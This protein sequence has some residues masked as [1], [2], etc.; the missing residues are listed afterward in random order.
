MTQE[1]SKKKTFEEVLELHQKR[2]DA[3]IEPYKDKQ[4]YKRLCTHLVSINMD[5]MRYLWN[6]KRNNHGNN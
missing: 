5:L 2:F 1:N 4:P 6:L 3:A